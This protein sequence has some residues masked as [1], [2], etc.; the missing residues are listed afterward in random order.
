VSAS[1]FGL[2]HFGAAN[3]ITAH[4]DT[5]YYPSA[6]QDGFDTFR[7]VYRVHV[8][9]L[10]NRCDQTNGYTERYYEIGSD[11]RDANN[12]NNYRNVSTLDEGARAW[13]CGEQAGQRGIRYNN[14]AYVDV[15]TPWINYGPTSNPCGP[16][17]DGTFHYVYSDSKYTTVY[18]NENQFEEQN[19][20]QC[21]NGGT[22]C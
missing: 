3:P 19:I 10:V 22:D 5:C 17:A 4:A 1:L 8:W 2:L 6:R 13:S 21:P 7:G 9:Y 18:V 15:T 11:V 16:Q 20:P 14:S 12:T